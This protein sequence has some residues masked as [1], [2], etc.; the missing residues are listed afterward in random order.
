MA[1]LL[2]SIGILIKYVNTNQLGYLFDFFYFRDLGALELLYEEAKCNILE[3]R[4]PC[5]VSQYTML[6]GIQARLELGPCNPQVHSNKY[7]RRVDVLLFY[8]ENIWKL[9]YLS[10]ILI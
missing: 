8:F 7:L 4:Y 10:Y 2:P 1:L 6:G 9:T 3:G 5:D